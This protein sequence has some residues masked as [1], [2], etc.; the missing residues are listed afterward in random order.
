MTSHTDRTHVYRFGDSVAIYLC[1]PDSE[2]VY[3]APV[4]ARELGET[5]IRYA[6]DCERVKFTKST[7][8]TSVHGK[9]YDHGGR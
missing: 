2:T 9:R 5:L 6:N 8:G 7:I 4:L 1:T 3:L